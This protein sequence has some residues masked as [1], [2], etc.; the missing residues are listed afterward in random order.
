[1]DLYAVPTPKNIKL[2]RPQVFGSRNR[3]TTARPRGG[4]KLQKQQHSQGLTADSGC[5]VAVELRIPVARQA[6][7]QPAIRAQITQKRRHAWG[8]V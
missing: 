8:A 4:L 7:A 5:P 6:A 3:T 1:M 2:E